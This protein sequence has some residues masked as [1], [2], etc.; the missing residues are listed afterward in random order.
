MQNSFSGTASGG[1]YGK[2]VGIVH[3]IITGAGVITGMSQPFIL[4]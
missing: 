1:V 3:N 2:A 4:I